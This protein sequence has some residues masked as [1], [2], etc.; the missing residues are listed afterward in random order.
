M[1]QMHLDFIQKRPTGFGTSRLGQ[2]LGPLGFVVE[3]ATSEDNGSA[4]TGSR[5]GWNTTPLYG[6]AF[7][8]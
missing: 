5:H 7:S 6:Q 8:M 2:R 4:M 3:P 1:R